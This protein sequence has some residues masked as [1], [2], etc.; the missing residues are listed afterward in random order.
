VS[1]SGLCAG[2]EVLH[3]MIIWPRFPGEGLES[4]MLFKLSIKDPDEANAS[5]Y[6]GGLQEFIKH[7]SFARCLYICAIF[8]MPATA[9]LVVPV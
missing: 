1:S 7:L 2:H 3:S 6:L 5:T 9:R 8:G 4:G